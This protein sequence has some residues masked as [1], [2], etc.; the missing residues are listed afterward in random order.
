M[1]VGGTEVSIGPDESRRHQNKRKMAVRGFITAARACSSF[2]SF[3][4]SFPQRQRLSLVALIYTARCFKLCWCDCM[5]IGC[6]SESPQTQC[7]LCDKSCVKEIWVQTSA[8]EDNQH[9]HMRALYAP[10][11]TTTTTPVYTNTA[12]LNLCCPLHHCL[13]PSVIQTSAV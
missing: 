4:L 2:T 5:E 12:H 1:R 10:P 6:V 13:C 8:G 11:P 3:P 7:R 9:N